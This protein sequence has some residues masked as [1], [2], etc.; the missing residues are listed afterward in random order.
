VA[1]FGEAEPPQ[2]LLFLAHWG[3]K[4]APVSEKTRFSEGSG[5]L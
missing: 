1:R 4:A 3:G 2:S 5:T